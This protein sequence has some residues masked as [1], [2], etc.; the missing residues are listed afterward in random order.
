M[1]D[2]DFRAVQK[3]V[4]SKLHN[5]SAEPL[6]RLDHTTF[7]DARVDTR[8]ESELRSALV[9]YDPEMYGAKGSQ[10]IERYYGDHL[11]FIY[12][13]RTRNARGEL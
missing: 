11:R 4:P 1:S 8:N 2:S 7:L 9:A 6:R 3:S 5:K 10:P 13:V 12:D